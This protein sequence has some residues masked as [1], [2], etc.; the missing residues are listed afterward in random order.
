MTTTVLIS[1]GGIAGPTL[2]YWLARHGFR[3][4]VVERSAGLRSSG[5]PVDVRGEAMPVAAAMGVVPELRA[6]ATRASAMSLID[7][8][9][10]RVARIRMRNAGGRG[11]EVEVPRA[12]LAAILHRAAADGTEMLFDDTITTLRQDPHGVD[13][14]FDRTPARRFDLVIGADGLHSTVRRLAFGAERA[15]VRHLGLFVATLPLGEP[16]DPPSEVLLYN[17]PGR[18]VSV[19]P[20]RGEALVAFIFRGRGLDDVE[21]SGHGAPQGDRPAGLRRPRVAGARP[22]RAASGSA[23]SVLRRGQQSRHA[24]VVARSGRAARRRSLVRLA[25]RR[26]AGGPFRAIG[27]A[28]RSR[29]RSGHGCGPAGPVDML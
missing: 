13:V 20:S 4:T 3:P 16:A 12:D 15:H 18:L 23:R 7:A 8:S 9:G 27:I 17:T 29:F 21:Q 1:G 10:R 25:V 2:A 6:A 19:H 5:N 14:T 24:V 11:T 28:F 26:T 22:A